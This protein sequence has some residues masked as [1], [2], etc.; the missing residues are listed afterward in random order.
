MTTKTITSADLG[1]S[2]ITTEVNLKEVFITEAGRL[3][4][5]L[6]EA[7]RLFNFLPAS[8]KAA[9]AVKHNRD[10]EWHYI[11]GAPFHLENKKIGKSS[12]LVPYVSS[13]IRATF[14]A[15]RLLTPINFFHSWWNQLDNPSKHYDALV[16]M[17]AVSN[18]TF[19]KKLSYEQAGLGVGSQ[20]ID[21]F[22]ETNSNGDFLLEVKCRLGQL[23]K[24]MERVQQVGHD[25][26][27]VRA[28]EPNTNFETLFKD[29]S[30]KFPPIANS[31]YIQGAIIFLPIQ[32]PEV[33]FEKYFLDMLKNNLHFV[34]FGTEDYETS[35]KV[36]TYATTLEIAERVNLVF[37]WVSGAK[38]TY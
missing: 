33:K 1:H 34:A 38:F 24:E 9:P 4:I 31:S 8:I 37:N 6:V 17:L 22:L 13:L 36:R 35:T 21:W 15:K 12:H 23:A 30:C 16:E 11:Y 25:G 32:V 18:V 19:D 28:S 20:K 7:E 2:F 29:T 3:D 14:T 26:K 10:S 27:Q 5:G